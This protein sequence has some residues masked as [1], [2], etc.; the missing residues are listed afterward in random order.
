M[1][2]SSSAS[3]IGVRD[4]VD[5]H[6][7]QVARH[8]DHVDLA[9]VR[10]CR[11][12]AS[13]AAAEA[14]ERPTQRREPSSLACAPR[15]REDWGL[16]PATFFAASR[17]V[18]VAGKGGVGKTTVTAALARAAARQGHRALIVE[19][20]GKSGL[21]SDVRRRGPRLRGDHPRRGRR[22]D[23]AADVRA[24]TL[25]SDDAM[26]EYLEDHGMSRVAKRLVSSGAIDTLATAAPG[27]KDIL[28]LGKVKQLERPTTA[29]TSSCSTP[30]PP[31]TP[32]PSCGRPGACSTPCGSVPSTTR[33]PR[34]WSC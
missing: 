5:Q 11:S 10:R 12:W 21:A 8:L 6:R 19:V 22:P 27:I 30:P 32:S 33:P 25:T 28:V 14:H 26:L 34:S 15:L 9:G 20:E 2:P 13:A 18:I 17:V 1:A 29:P 31:A 7:V 24:R 16:D 4:E 23:G 3:S